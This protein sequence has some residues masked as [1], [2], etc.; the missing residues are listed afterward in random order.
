MPLASAIPSPPHSPGENGGSAAFFDVD[1]TLIQSTIVHYYAYFR[2]R[3]MSPLTARFWYAAFL[4]KCLYFLVVDRI[5]RS[6][7]NT[8]FYRSYAGLPADQTKAAADGCYREVIAPR[9]FGQAAECVDEHRRADRP[10][11]PRPTAQKRSPPEAAGQ[12]S[13]QIRRRESRSNLAP[14]DQDS[15]HEKQTYQRGLSRTQASRKLHRTSSW[16]A[17]AGSTRKQGF[18]DKSET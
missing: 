5:D 2:R 18:G 17:K 13:R 6:R 15:A 7:F 9:W 1:G 4:V 12:K 10:M 14:Y 8:L 11:H 3:R 16:Y